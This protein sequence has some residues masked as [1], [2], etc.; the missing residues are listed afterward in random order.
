[1][2][3]ELKK[4]IQA[5]QIAE[6]KGIKAVLAAVVAL[7][8]SSYRRPG[9][10]MLLL[11]NGT[12]V[13]AVSGGC[14]EKEI[15]RQSES[16]FTTGIPKIMTYDGR[17][18]LG[19]EGI[20]YILLE[21]FSPPKRFIDSFY[22]TVHDRTSFQVNS[23]FQKKDSTD[24]KY[25][26]LFQFGN[27][28]LPVHSGS[29]PDTS[30]EVLNQQMEPG[31]QLLIVG[32]EHDA[33]QLCSYASIAGWEVTVIATPSEEK[34]LQDFPGAQELLAIAP[35]E[36]QASKIDQ[37][38]VV[39]LMS[40]SYVKDLQY[41][42]QLYKSSPSY[43]GLLGPFKRR[44]QLLNEFLERC[45]EVESSFFDVIHGPA[46]LDI[47]AET[48]QEIAIAIMAEILLVTRERIP[49]KLKNKKGSIHSKSE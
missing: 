22:K 10:A 7:E 16:V 46:G 18:R 42:I 32:A 26:T 9:V 33:V 45:P 36:F 34:Q 44:E 48:P 28:K 40:H 27:Q 13:G 19:C 39:V 2:T 12:M 35:E 47:G 8:G 3:H 30:L 1:M 20:L 31:M 41:L 5:Y 25:G 4:I 15:Y 38:T 49:V 37:Q 17:Y 24:K 43:I 21:P 23:Y 11:E 29:T 6:K 14:V